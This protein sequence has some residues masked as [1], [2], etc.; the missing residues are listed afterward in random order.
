MI[1]EHLPMTTLYS[2]L[3]TLYI[4]LLELLFFV[5]YDLTFTHFDFIHVFFFLFRNNL[6]LFL[7]ELQFLKN[8]AFTIYNSMY[9]YN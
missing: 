1:S 7:L 2:I 6:D 8:V 9:I 3:Y 5:D 4:K